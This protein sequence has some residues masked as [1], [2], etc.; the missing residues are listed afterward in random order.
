MLRNWVEHPLLSTG[1]IR[2]RQDAV[3]ELAGNFMLREDLGEELSHVSDL[4]RLITKIVYGT[5][6]PRDLLSVS[7]TAQ[8]LPAVKKLIASCTCHRLT[9]LA[10]ELDTLDD[11]ANEISRAIKPDANVMLREGNIIA[12][13]YNADVDHLRAS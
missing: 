1:D 10:A 13:G 3:G 7:A 8:A 2:E 4:E 6:N 11:V 5:A 12:D 9:A